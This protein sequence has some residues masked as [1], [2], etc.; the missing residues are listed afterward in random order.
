MSWLEHLEGPSDAELRAI[1]QEGD[2][3]AAEMRLVDAEAALAAT[4]TNAN[5]AAYLRALLE[6][7]DLHDFTDQLSGRSDEIGLIELSWEVAG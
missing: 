2:V 6:V 7:V 5:V 3:L 1:E 4:P